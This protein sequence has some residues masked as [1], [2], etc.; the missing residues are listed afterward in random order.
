[1]P[2]IQIADTTK[3]EVTFSLPIDSAQLIAIGNPLIVQSSSGSAR[4][5]GVVTESDPM[6][7]AQDRTR[8][9]RAS[10][11]TAT[12]LPGE[13]VRILLPLDTPESTVTVSETAITYA[14]QGTAVYVIDVS[15]TPPVAQLRMVTVGDTQE[16]RVE[17][18][19]GLE[20]GE[21]V[22]SAGQHKLFSGAQVVINEDS[23]L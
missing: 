12:V 18:V 13:F 16:G 1:M 15:K 22:V 4:V 21:T 10:L 5:E 6:L 8:R 23:P 3:A 20:V 17:V 14:L 11:A 7:N 2:L 9:F 19:R